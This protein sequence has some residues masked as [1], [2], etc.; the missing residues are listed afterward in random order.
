MLLLK[1]SV[2]A[3]IKEKERFLRVRE[4][5]THKE[6]QKVKVS[7]PSHRNIEKI[8]MGMFINM[9]TDRFYIDDSEFDDLD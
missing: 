7:N 1:D 2:V 3:K 9:D 6:I 5:G 8:M 4:L